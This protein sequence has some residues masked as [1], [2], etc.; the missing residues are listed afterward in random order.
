M[1]I[2]LELIERMRP[3]AAG[4]YLMPAFNRYDLSAEIIDGVKS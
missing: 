2:A 4:I 3:W 1:R